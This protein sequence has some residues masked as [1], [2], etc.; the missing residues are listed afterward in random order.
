MDLNILVGAVSRR[1]N[2]SWT[3]NSHV[4]HL[5]FFPRAPHVQSPRMVKAW[6]DEIA[7]YDFG[8]WKWDGAIHDMFVL[9]LTF[10]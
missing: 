3:S 2:L 1:A 5:R 9:C 6:Y 4:N 7:D 8:H 10:S